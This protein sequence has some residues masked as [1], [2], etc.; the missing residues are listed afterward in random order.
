MGFAELLAIGDRAT[1]EILGSPVIYTPG[2]GD[3]VTVTGIF[4]KGYVRVD[5]GNPGVASYG[6]AVFL[7]LADL[8]SDPV[9]DTDATVTIGGVA[10]LPHEPQ[11][12]G[13][14]GI[15]LLLHEVV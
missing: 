7:T 4:D 14:G 15:V 1:R 5:L 13:L 6:P 3:P 2:T 12:D 9:A 10:Y 8:P 11:P